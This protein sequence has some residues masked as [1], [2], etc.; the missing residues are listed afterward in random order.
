M[1][2]NIFFNRV[3][4]LKNNRIPVLV[5]VLFI[6]AL[7]V[8]KFVF[9]D[10]VYIGQQYEKNR[11]M[12]SSGEKFKSG[13]LSVD[14]SIDQTLQDIESLQLNTVNVPIIIDIPSLTSN[15]MRI[16]AESE[17]KAI[18]LIRMLRYRGIN[19]ILEPYPYIQ[20]GEKY[21]T[22]LLPDNVDLWFTNWKA[23]LQELIH[24]VAKPNKVYAICIGS[25]FEKFE[26]RTDYWTD[27]ADFVRQEFQGK[28]TYRTNWWY[29]AVWNT[30]NDP[31]N[32]TYTPKLNN[33]IFGKVD[34]ISVAA[35]FELSDKET[36]TVENLISA[37]YKT[38]I[39]NREQNI[40][41]ELKSLS[42][43]WNKPIFFG[44]LGFPKRNGAA[45]HPWNPIPTDIMNGQEQANC[46]EAY[47]RVFTPEPWHMGFSVFAIGKI[48]S[49]KNYYPSFQSAEII[50]KWY[51]E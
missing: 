49:E 3:S 39:Y 40:Y 13:N 31:Q 30:D 45:T 32:D 38:K 36:N 46:F 24:D 11:I 6:I 8:V 25:N 35:Y 4:G 20:N 41:S 2:I 26:D 9:I 47:R 1:F 15:T 19:V 17:K 29:T 16:N 22:A 34:F 33:P 28:M 10:I 7:I 14:Y 42:G 18:K 5:F 48:D 21:E 50:R 37:I 27:V 12:T 23:V 43:K 44:E 51:I